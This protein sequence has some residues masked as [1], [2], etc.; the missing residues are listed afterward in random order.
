MS[1]ETGIK[2]KPSKTH[3]FWEEIDYLG[4]NITLASIKML[5]S[6]IEKIVKWPKSTTGKELVSFLGLTGYYRGSIRDYARTTAEL[7]SQKKEKLVNW[8]LELSEKFEALKS[9][10]S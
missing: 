1:R 10:F 6:Y 2:F 8:T 9:Q 5:D 3:L 7:N 4:H